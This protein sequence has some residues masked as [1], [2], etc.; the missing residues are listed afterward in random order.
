MCVGGGQ[1]SAELFAA[2]ALQGNARAGLK[3]AEA[4]EPDCR[5]NDSTS[6]PVVGEV[7]RESTDRKVESLEISAN[8]KGSR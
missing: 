6:A 3:F 7:S 2:R 4:P 5:G 8:L 1:I